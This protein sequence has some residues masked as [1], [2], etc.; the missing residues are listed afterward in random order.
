M[1]KTY[2]IVLDSETIVTCTNLKILCK[3]IRIHLLDSDDFIKKIVVTKEEPRLCPQGWYTNESLDSLKTYL[4]N[5]Y[6][7]STHNM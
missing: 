5:K 4:N 7:V 6:A 3:N 2:G 1:K